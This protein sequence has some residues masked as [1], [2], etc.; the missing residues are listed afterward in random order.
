MSTTVMT[1]W[2]SFNNKYSENGRFAISQSINFYA[3]AAIVRLSPQWQPLG[4]V[5][6]SLYAICSISCMG[7]LSLYGLGELATNYCCVL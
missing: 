2:F 1:T 7:S 4:S 6:V 5:R 3:S